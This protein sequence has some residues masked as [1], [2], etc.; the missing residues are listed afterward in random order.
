[1]ILKIQGN[2]A[3]FVSLSMEIMGQVIRKEIDV[4]QI[5]LKKALPAPQL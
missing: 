3:V 2:Q 1:L 5:I 4:C